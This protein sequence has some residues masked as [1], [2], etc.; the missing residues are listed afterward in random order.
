LQGR[1]FQSTLNGNNHE[2]YEKAQM[3]LEDDLLLNSKVIAT[4]RSGSYTHLVAQT[5][6]GPKLIKAKKLLLTIP[7]IID[8]LSGLDLDTNEKSLF[9]QFE[10]GSWFTACLKNTGIP[11]HKEVRNFGADTPYNVPALPGPYFIQ[12]CDIPGVFNVK[13]CSPFPM[14]ESDGKEEIL[15]AVQRLKTAGTLNT[16]KPEFLE[17]HAHVPFEMIVS[18]EAIKEGFYKKLYA[19]QGEK[20]TY[21]TGAAF[22]AQDSSKLWVFTDKLIEKIIQGMP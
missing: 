15:A 3:E 22:H 20:N 6:T 11:E 7:P 1:T 10:H 5:P 12:A 21:W 8:N 2:L 18:T 9:S 19:L 13:Y 14:S 16:T 17:F 4:D